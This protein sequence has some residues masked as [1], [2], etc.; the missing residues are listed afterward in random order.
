MITVR[1]EQSRQEKNKEPRNETLKEQEK[2]QKSEP[3]LGDQQD[4]GLYLL[5]KEDRQLRADHVVRLLSTTGYGH[6]PKDEAEGMVE[7]MIRLSC[8][9]YEMLQTVAKD[10]GAV[11]SAY[12]A[13]K[14]N[15]EKQQKAWQQTIKR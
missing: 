1:K 9:M 8:L 12:E 2:S 15:E 5:I 7:Q 11:L 13:G 6:L 3:E 10:T 4:D 14:A